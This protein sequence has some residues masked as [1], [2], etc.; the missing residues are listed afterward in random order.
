MMVDASV[1]AAILL[2]ED[3][4]EAFASAIGNAKV[5]YTTPIAV[6]E[7]CAALMRERKVSAEDATL[8]VREL[9]ATA[10]IQI[11]TITDLIA[12]AAVRAFGRYGKGTK[13]QARL[14]MGDCFSYACAHAWRSPLLFKGTEFERTDVRK[15]LERKPSGKTRSNL[16]LGLRASFARLETTACQALDASQESIASKRPAD[17]FGGAQAGE[18]AATHRRRTAPG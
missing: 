13:H 4:A 1:L 16:N 12:E 2:K 7:A 15:A 6:F 18:H 3:E 9:L 8:L 17:A 14:N 10:S 5:V 11:V